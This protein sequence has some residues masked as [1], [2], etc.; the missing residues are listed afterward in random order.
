MSINLSLSYCGRLIYCKK[1]NRLG[2]NSGK[3]D[4]YNVMG[5]IICRVSTSNF[6]SPVYN[7]YSTIT[8]WGKYQCLCRKT[9][10]ITS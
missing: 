6:L 4:Q 5:S 1:N 7:G 2:G 10:Q 3:W 8:V 9:L